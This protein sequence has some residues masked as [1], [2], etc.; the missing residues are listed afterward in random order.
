MV[1]YSVRSGRIA[2][3]DLAVGEKRAAVNDVA[4]GNVSLRHLQ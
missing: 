2:P 1:M 3:D 4:A